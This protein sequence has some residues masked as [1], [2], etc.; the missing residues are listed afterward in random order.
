MRKLIV[1][2]AVMLGCAGQALALT[3]EQRTALS[4]VGQVFAGAK[5]CDAIALN[6]MAIGALYLR[7]AIDLDNREQY[8]IVLAKG[9]ETVEAWRGRDQSDACVGAMLL[10]G[11]DGENVPGLLRWK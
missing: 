1:A 9:Q 3:Q 2:L 8:A 11:P 10:Y 7:F 6:E 4:V 5:M